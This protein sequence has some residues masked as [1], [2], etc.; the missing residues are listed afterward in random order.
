MAV[1]VK[2]FERVWFRP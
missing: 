1:K 2:L